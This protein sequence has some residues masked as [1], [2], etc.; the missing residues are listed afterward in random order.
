G[1]RQLRQSQALFVGAAEL[2]Q[3]IGGTRVL[4]QRGADLGGAEV[5][6]GQRRRQRRRQLRAAELVERGDVLQGHGVGLGLQAAGLRRARDRRRRRG[7][8]RRWARIPQ[9]RRQHRAQQQGGG[10]CQPRTPGRARR[11]R[12]GHG[13]GGGAGGGAPA[14]GRA[15]ARPRG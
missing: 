1:Q 10:E 13:G 8:V 11:G 5:E 15:R 6:L 4:A 3:Q 7:E 2:C 14:R 9:Q 12:A